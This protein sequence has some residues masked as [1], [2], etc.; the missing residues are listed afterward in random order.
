[1]IA[2]ILSEYFILMSVKLRDTCLTMGFFRSWKSVPV[3]SGVRFNTF[4]GFDIRLSPNKK[5]M[6]PR[7][8]IQRDQVAGLRTGWLGCRAIARRLGR[9]VSTISR[10]LRRSSTKSGSYRS[11]LADGGYMIAGSFQAC[12]KRM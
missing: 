7:Q 6:L 5:T 4:A 10:E 9:S 11:H 12:W 1:M 8:E 2:I 3:A